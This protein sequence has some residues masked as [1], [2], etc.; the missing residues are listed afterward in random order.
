MGKQARCQMRCEGG[1]AQTVG[2]ANDRRPIKKAVSSS[3]AQPGKFLFF[4]ALLIHY[5][6]I[7][8]G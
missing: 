5:Q 4:Y 7:V 6:T 8:H 1:Q 3:I 2:F